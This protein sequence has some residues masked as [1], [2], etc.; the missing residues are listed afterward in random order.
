MNDSTKTLMKMKKAG[1]LVRLAQRKNGPKS[2]KRGQGALLRALLENDGA[3]QRELVQT[4]GMDR[5]ALKDIV[6]KAER[7]GYVT[8][9]KTDEKKV[10]AVK[11]TE[12][13]KKVAEKHD[14][15]QD[16]TSDE[17]LAVL[18]DEE[19]AQLDA[20]NEKLIVGLKEAGI[21]GKKKGHK[22]HRHGHKHGHGHHG[23]G[24]GKCKHR[25]HCHR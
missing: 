18:T 11:L 1:K 7:N 15:A 13:G 10:Y 17:I 25:R 9:E 24:H 14:K 21:D 6:R 22:A 19:R 16:K 4:L 12:E 2:Y 5:G 23:H 20:I 3:T 8:I